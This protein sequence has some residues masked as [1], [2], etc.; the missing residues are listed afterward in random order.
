MHGSYSRS[1]HETVVE[2]QL[3]TLIEHAYNDISRVWIY[4]SDRAFSEG[5]RKEFLQ[6]SRALAELDTK[7]TGLQAEVLESA[8]QGKNDE[9]LTAFS[10]QR[11]VRDLFDESTSVDDAVDAV[12][13][14]VD[15]GCNT[16]GLLRRFFSD[17]RVVNLRDRFVAMLDTK[18]RKAA[19][20]MIDMPIHQFY[21]LYGVR[22]DAAEL[23][24]AKLEK[25]YE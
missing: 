1:V 14:L 17:Q 10:Y 21:L 7:I 5:W 13:F 20:I 2:I 12:Q 16:N 19:E 6:V 9:W 4:K 24:V 25:S 23:F 22:I 11:I 18:G 3:Q 15:L 8:I